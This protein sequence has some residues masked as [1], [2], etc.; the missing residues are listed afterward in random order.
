MNPIL[1]NVI[2]VIVGIL[3]GS[4]VNISLVEVGNAVFPIEGYDMTTPEGLAGAISQFKPINYL[5]PFLGHALGTL[6]GA[7]LAAI[8]AASHKMKIALAI[9]F[10][11]LLGGITMVVSYPGA[12]WFNVTDLLL[13]Y[14]PMGWLSGIIAT[15]KSQHS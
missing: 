11:F 7:L 5:F 4:F 9:G 8:I 14:I 2:A 10:L 13:A 12:M 1:R 6:V 3:V 15:R